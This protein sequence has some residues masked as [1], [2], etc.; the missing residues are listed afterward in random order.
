M[1]KKGVLFVWVEERF[2]SIETVDVRT[3]NVICGIRKHL[4]KH[5]FNTRKSILI[6]MTFKNNN[7]TKV[8]AMLEKVVQIIWVEDRRD[9]IRTKEC[10]IG[11]AL[12]GI[13]K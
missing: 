13:Q 8:L 7:W 2:Y 10:S 5:Y 12:C 4:W 6:F 11:N 1:F 3:E 9:S